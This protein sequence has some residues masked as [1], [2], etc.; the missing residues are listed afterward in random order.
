MTIPFSVGVHSATTNLYPLHSPANRALVELW[1]CCRVVEAVVAR[2]RNPRWGAR[3]Q[4]C[5]VNRESCGGSLQPPT[6]FGGRQRVN[7]GN[8]GRR[9]IQA[10]MPAETMLRVS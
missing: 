5:L 6:H 8:E 3:P 4:I 2:N 9:Q 1:S 10:G 7:R